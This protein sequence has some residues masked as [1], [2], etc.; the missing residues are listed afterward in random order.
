MMKEDLSYEKLG[1]SKR[2]KGSNRIGE[3]LERN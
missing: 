2:N 1:L 3:I